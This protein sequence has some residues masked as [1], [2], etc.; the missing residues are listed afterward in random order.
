M[1]L[2]SPCGI[3]E[4]EDVKI[5]VSV[6]TYLRRRITPKGQTQSSLHFATF[7]CPVAASL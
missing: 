5:V 6:T 2:E 1:G 7:P 4:Y 3:R